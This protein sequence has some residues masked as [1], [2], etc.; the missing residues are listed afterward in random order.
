MILG[1]DLLLMRPVVI[2]QVLGIILSLSVSGSIFQNKAIQNI[3]SA[4]PDISRDELAQLITG[5]SGHLYKSLSESDQ[6]V[7]VHQ[8][9]RA[10][11][12]SF[13]YLIGTTALGLITS[14]LLSV[15]L[16]SMKLISYSCF[17]TFC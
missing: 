10:I 3:G 4:L 8:I 12:D 14:L 16:P 7:V 1:M 15:S 9:M 13:Y 6:E 5:A 11:R 2:A 17:K